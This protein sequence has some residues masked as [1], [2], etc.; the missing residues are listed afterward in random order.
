MCEKKEENEKKDKAND[1]DD[2]ISKRYE[3]KKRL[4]KGAYGIVWKAVDKKSREVVAVKKIFDAFRNQTDAQRTFREIMFLQAF[5]DHPNIIRLRGLHKASNNRDIYLVFDYMDSDLHHVIKKGNILKDIHRR[6]IMYQLLRATR[7]LHSGD[8]I[9][10]DQKPSNILINAECRIKLADFGLARSLAN[11]YTEEETEGPPLLT[12]YVATRWYRAP[13]ILVAS[14]RYT[15]GVDMWSLGCI[16]GEMLLGKP[17]FP[18]SSTVNQ[19]ERIMAALP[20]PTPQE[21]SNMCTGYGKSLLEGVIGQKTNLK[22]MIKSSSQEAIDLVTK[23]LI[24]DPG[25]RLTASQALT[26]PYVSKFCNG[27]EIC[28][29]HSIIPPLNDDVQLSV[30]E[31][32]NK[33]YELIANGKNTISKKQGSTSSSSKNKTLD[34]DRSRKS[35]ENVQKKLTKYIE[36][37]GKRDE[38]TDLRKYRSSSYKNHSVEEL[39]EKSGFTNPVIATKSE[40]SQKTVV[41]KIG[42]SPQHRH[43][44][45]PVQN[46]NDCWS[47]WSSKP[48]IGIQNCGDECNLTKT[49]GHGGHFIN[50]SPKPVKGTTTISYHQE[51]HRQ[52]NYKFGNISSLPKV[53]VQ[54]NDFVNHYPDNTSSS[55]SLTR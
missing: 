45:P 40:P 37:R 17:L 8:V 25:K 46:R 23:L 10:R 48:F 21:I 3:M 32:R 42:S 29:D 18:G 13:E 49:S 31:Y 27:S 51:K 47:E 30:S 15:K 4:G 26:H 12:D 33:L 53:A 11:Y 24:F 5:K 28:L 38:M 20:K 36:N 14:K 9:H 44:V 55:S 1:I 41:K 34:V 54:K 6:Y 2:H 52:N 50:A 39:R 7:Y 22:D 43:N 19:I 35:I 16:L